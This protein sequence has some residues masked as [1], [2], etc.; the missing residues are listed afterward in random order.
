MAHLLDWFFPRGCVLC[1]ELLP[2]TQKERVLCKNCAEKIPFLTGPLC[3][4]CGATL[5]AAE[6]PL[7]RSCSR[8]EMVFR[9]GFA[10]FAY[11]DIREGIHLFKYRKVRENGVPLAGFM[12][13][14]LCTHHPETLVET[15]LLVPVPMFPAKEKARG[16]NQS[17]LL[18]QELS[19][20]SGLPY[21]NA[22]R[23]VRNTVPQSELSPEDRKQNLRDAV[24]L[25]EGADVNGKHI[26]L[27]DDIFTT[28]STI[29]ACASILYKM[30][31]ETVDF[32][33]LSITHEIE[34]PPK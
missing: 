10:A 5:Q 12:Y 9:R 7:C 6:G 20:L 15:D 17:A 3:A 34:I 27:I 4:K 18:A 25:V 23:R 21:E 16:F 24:A 28:G 8:Q 14:Y 32:Y 2:V 33:T 26:L 13:A 19:R 30:G 29:N 22:L 31:A 11:E 1:A